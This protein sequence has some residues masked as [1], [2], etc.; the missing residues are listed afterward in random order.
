MTITDATLRAHWRSLRFATRCVAVQF[1]LNPD[2]LFGDVLERIWQARESFTGNDDAFMQWC[3]CITYNRC[4]DIHRYE[5]RR[6]NIMQP[7]T[8]GAIS[9]AGNLMAAI[10]ARDILR[11]FKEYITVNYGYHQRNILWMKAKGYGIKTGEIGEGNNAYHCA[12]FGGI[13]KMRTQFKTVY[14]L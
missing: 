14:T 4:K 11:R 2:D 13:K 8:R 10:E 1:R 12:L 7:N 3:L 9:Q 5:H 6:A